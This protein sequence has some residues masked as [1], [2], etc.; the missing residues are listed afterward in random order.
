MQDFA[1]DNYAGVCPEALRALVEANA[2][3]HE[4]AYGDDSWT[5]RVCDRLRALF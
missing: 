1:S 2:S 5:R 3:G 4:V